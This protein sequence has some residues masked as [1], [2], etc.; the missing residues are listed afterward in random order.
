LIYDQLDKKQ[1]I[2]VPEQYLKALHS[3]P[4]VSGRERERHTHRDT[5]RYRETVRD[6]KRQRR[7]QRETKRQRETER[8]RE[9]EPLKSSNPFKIVSLIAGQAL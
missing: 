8:E 9:T 2:M 7:R 4:Q 5:E 1:T 3:D 6:R